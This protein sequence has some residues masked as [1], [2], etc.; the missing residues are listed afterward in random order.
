MSQQPS[1]SLK[2]L[3][4]GKVRDL[5][6]IDDQRMLMVAS[7]RLSAFD[8]ILQQPIPDKGKILTEISNFWFNKLEHIIPNHFTGDQV[9]DVVSAQEL[10]L[11]EGRAVVAKRLKPVAVEAIVRG[12]LVGSGWKEYQ[13]S[14][15][16]CGIQL[17][18]GLQEAQQL[19][20]PIFTPSTKAE[21][22]DH[23]ENIS[24]AQCAAIIGEDLAKQ[25]RDASLALY[26]AAV[27]YAA[28][29]GIIIADTK[30]EFGLDNDGT[31][32]L[33]D[34][35]LTPDSSRFWPADS[36][37]VGTNPPSFDKQFVRDWLESSGWNKEPPAP[38]IPADVAQ[39]TADKYRE[40]LQ[41]LTQ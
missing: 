6:E 32:T 22:G 11:V 18:A 20:E 19:P 25:V 1:L 34:E 38:A 21:V 13:R 28:T 5:Y 31:L 15:T 36:Y 16:V 35:A 33:M 26:Q 3:Y 17:P 39:K 7:D 30:F 41:R 12:Y 29:R 27:E 9:S 2:K 23:D 10:P 8:V 14:G 37:Q 40:A 24:F 4:S